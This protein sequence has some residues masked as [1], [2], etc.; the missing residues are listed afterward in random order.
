MSS[1]G[2]NASDQIPL[3]FGHDTALGID[4]FMPSDSNRDALS[5]LSR[6]P[7]WPAPALVL[8]GPEGAGK[9]HL[10]MIWAARSHAQTLDRLKLGDTLNLNAKR[11]YLLDPGEPVA[12]EV[13]L[14]QLYNRLREDGGHLLLTATRPSHRWGL[15][16][17]D[18]ASR[19]AA[20]PS[21][22]IGAPDD[23]L[24]AALLLK[25]FDDRQLNVP[26][27]VIR[28]LVTHMERSF[29]AA[30][31]LVDELDR[32]SLARKRPITVPLAR[33]AIGEKVDES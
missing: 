8:H 4:D 30:R 18:L 26:E 9:T 28:Y 27:P 2:I 14:L 17:P 15:N 16:L 10:A 12:D 13:A 5:W 32:L 1:S 6:W 19:L 24:L 31:S 29:A 33:L 21:V 7:D 25:M 22:A 3:T 20:A 11:C 23:G